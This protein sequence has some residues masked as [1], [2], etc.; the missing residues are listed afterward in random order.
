MADDGKTDFIL[1]N[2]DVL[3]HEI[4]NKHFDVAGPHFTKKIKEITQMMADKNQKTIEELDRFIKKLKDM[5]VVTAK[6]VA[7]C[8]INVAFFIA[9]SMKDM[10]YQ[11]VYGIE[12]KCILADKDEM[13]YISQSLEAKMTKQHKKMK[14][15]RAM[16]MYST[17][18][19]GLSK[20]DFD[21][22]RR[23]FIMNYGYQ[24]MVTLMNLQ[25]AGLFKQKLDKKQQGYFEWNWNKIKETFNLIDENMNRMA[26]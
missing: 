9:Q 3:F 17:T 18:Q 23:V 19:G 25:D 20:V 16:C 22:L 11:H 8:H 15:L 2:E 26:P 6:K 13:K 21:T 4:R 7:T 14:V 1:T 5:D 10:D 24:E 12:Q